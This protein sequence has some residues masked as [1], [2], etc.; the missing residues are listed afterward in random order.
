MRKIRAIYTIIISCSFPSRANSSPASLSLPFRRVEI[1]R[2]EKFAISRSCI[3]VK[4]PKGICRKSETRNVSHTCTWT[5]THKCVKGHCAHIYFICRWKKRKK[6][7]YIHFRYQKID[8]Y[9][10][11]RNFGLST[12][13]FSYTN[14]ETAHNFV[15]S[16]TI[17]TSAFLTLASNSIL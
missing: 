5:N 8:I 10:L 17:R 7:G 3:V 14:L 6:R 9:R 16:F 12:K 11:S 1:E 15:S 4:I 2:V 13:T